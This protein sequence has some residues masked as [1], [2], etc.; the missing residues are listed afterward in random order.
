MRDFRKH[1]VFA[2]LYGSYLKNTTINLHNSSIIF[3]R[4]FFRDC[5]RIVPRVAGFTFWP[6]TV[7]E[8]RLRS[9]HEM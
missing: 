9:A 1:A 7:P 8:H 3:L 5:L 6:L 2:L 4:L